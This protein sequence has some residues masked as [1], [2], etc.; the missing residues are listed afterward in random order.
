[1]RNQKTKVLVE[2]GVM[3]ALAII[4]SYLRLG[5]MPQGG[6][7]SLQMVPIFIIALRWGVFPGV[8]T[9][10]AF[11]LMQI[12]LGDAVIAQPLQGFLDYPLAFGVVGLSG[13]FSKRQVL[14]V[15]F[16]GFFRFICHF[17]AGV[18]FFAEYAGDQNVFVYS[19]VYNITYILPEVIIAALITPML[20]S[21]LTGSAADQKEEA[22]TFKLFLSAAL[23]LLITVFFMED[24]KLE[25]I[26]EYLF[27]GS[28]GLGWLLVLYLNIKD[29]VKSK[30]KTPL[31]VFG[32]TQLIT[33]VAFILISL[34]AFFSN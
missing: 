23:P 31:I 24:F 34:I 28:V 13:L 21:K 30:I 17:I 11:G 3:L 6:S 5:R 27:K 12:F 9:G 33:L 8:L 29:Y 18:V 4:L 32:Y 7:V 26:N 19:G 1:M 20:L 15:V 14:G 10:A 2:A 22:K 25:F 16:G